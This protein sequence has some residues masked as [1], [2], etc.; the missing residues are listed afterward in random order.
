MT[1]RCSRTPEKVLSD[2]FAHICPHCGAL[3]T[4][5]L[6]ECSVCRKLACERCGNV[7]IVGGERKVTH[8]ECLKKDE[9]GFTMIKFVK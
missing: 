5:R 3:E 8:H 4:R 1:A 9:G 6:G 7:Q 2:I